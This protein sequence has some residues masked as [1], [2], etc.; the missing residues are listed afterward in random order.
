M[1]ARTQVIYN[2]KL[3]CLSLLLKLDQ[4]NELFLPHGRSKL[5]WFYQDVEVEET[6][7][8]EM[9]ICWYT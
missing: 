7:S 3:N 6:D 4:I 5:M 9:V 8:F 1:T 2:T